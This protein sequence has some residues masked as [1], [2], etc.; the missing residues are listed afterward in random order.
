MPQPPAGG[1]AQRLPRQALAG[2]EA[3]EL[4]V[5]RQDV[6]REAPAETERATVVVA[7][8]LVEGGVVE[9]A[10]TL[11]HPVDRL[12]GDRRLHVLAA[13]ARRRRVR[14]VPRVE[15]DDDRVPLGDLL[16]GL[17]GQGP[18]GLHLVDVDPE[19]RLEIVRRRLEER[20]LVALEV[21]PDGEPHGR[22][23]LVAPR[24]QE[25]DQDVGVAVRLEVRPLAE[26]ELVRAV[27]GG[28]E[29]EEARRPAPGHGA[30]GS[31]QSRA[32]T[33][34]G[35]DSGSSPCARKRASASRSSPKPRQAEWATAPSEV[36]SPKT[37]AK[38]SWW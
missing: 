26:V 24:V 5:R 11:A 12:D 3:D 20:P 29:A 30:H 35:Q 16:R 15:L 25:L 17:V 6:L 18:I 2:V 4:G 1:L 32:L 31:P 37:D 7:P 9:V 13:V 27:R 34:A 22:E 19:E 8:E 36:V 28:I 33:S 10:E 21:H 38:C 23:R 14:Q